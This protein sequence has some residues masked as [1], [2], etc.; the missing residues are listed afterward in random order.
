MNPK[1]TGKCHLETSTEYVENVKDDCSVAL[2]WNSSQLITLARLV[3]FAQLVIFGWWYLVWYFVLCNAFYYCWHKRH[4]KFPAGDQI[5]RWT[6]SKIDSA[7][8]RSRYPWDYW[9]VLIFLPP[10]EILKRLIWPTVRLRRT[11]IWIYSGY[12]NTSTVDQY[13]TY[14]KSMAYKNLDYIIIVSYI[15]DHM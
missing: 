6:K 14:K 5:E 8:Y 10:E 15:M 2:P 3:I 4:V 1:I 9:F 11:F 12:S 13:S 7:W